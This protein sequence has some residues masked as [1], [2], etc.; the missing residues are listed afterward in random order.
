MCDEKH[1]EE[2]KCWYNNISYVE[3][4]K[5]NRFTNTVGPPIGNWSDRILNAN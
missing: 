3:G 4:K 1:C 5:A 2:E